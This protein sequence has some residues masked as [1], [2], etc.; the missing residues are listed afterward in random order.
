VFTLLAMNA[1]VLCLEQIPTVDVPTLVGTFGLVPNRFM[2]WTSL[3]GSAH[4]PWRYLPLLSAMFLH[5]GWLHF[6]TNMLYL[7]TFGRVLEARLGRSGLIATYGLSGIAAA[8]GQLLAHPGSNAAMVGASGAIAGLLGA[9]LICFP[10]ARL[11]L[12][13]P[14]YLVP[15]VLRIRAMWFLLAW[16]G[17]QVCKGTL[18]LLAHTNDPPVAWWAHVAGF[19]AGMTGALAG[20]AFP[21][22]EMRR[23]S[24]APL[25]A[26]TAGPMRAS[27]L[28]APPR[29]SRVPNWT[30]WRGSL[31]P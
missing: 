10:R 22:E 25:V 7:W 20:C 27:Q 18:E 2:H 3:G 1:L 24:V 13:F 23:A 11:T 8:L 31:V 4:D 26:T 5:D 9:Y 29:P 6:A 19:V 21:G 15:W 17:L 16:F 28:P 30:D 14:F 12:A